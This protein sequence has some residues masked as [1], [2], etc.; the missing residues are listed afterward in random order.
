[1]LGELYYHF[2]NDYNE[3]QSETPIQYARRDGDAD[4]WCFR[5]KPKWYTTSKFLNPYETV[6]QNH[7]KEN[8]VI[9]CERVYQT[10]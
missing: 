9:I 4:N 3:Q 6:E 7:I 5:T 1:L 8:T 10:R 2:I